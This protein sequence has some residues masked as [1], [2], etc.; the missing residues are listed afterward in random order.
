[1]ITSKP[2]VIMDYQKLAKDLKE[3]LKLVYPEGFHDNIIWFSDSK[4]HRISALRF[5]TDEKVYML[6]MSSEMAIEIMEDDDDFGD[7][8]KLKSKV[9][10]SYA[11]KHSDVDYLSEYLDEEEPEDEED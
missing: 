5:E 10:K 3:Q 4:G 8:F 2:K 1:M 11:D 6:R 7:D 9:H